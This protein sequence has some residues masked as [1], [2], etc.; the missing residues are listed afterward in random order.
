MSIE[1]NALIKN[2]T[3]ILI[4]STS[5]QNVVG[6]KWIFHTK[7]KADGSIDK[8][9]TC[10]VVKGYSQRPEVD[11]DNNFS[12]VLKAVKICVVLTLAVT[13]KWPILQLDMNNAFLHGPL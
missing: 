12:P 6:C 11:F 5:D 10:L 2:G 7:R 9:K 1:Y 13:N 8:Y 3:W 4:P